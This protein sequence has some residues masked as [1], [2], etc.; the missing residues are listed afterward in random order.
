MGRCVVVS[1]GEIS[2]YEMMSSLVRE[3]DFVIYCDCALRHRDKLSVRADLTVGDFDSFERP[4]EDENVI[5]LPCEKDDTDTLFALRH[6]LSL[7]YRD[8]LILGALGGRTDHAL[9]NIFLL[10]FLRDHDAMGMI[11]TELEDIVL[12]DSEK[13]PVCE[14]DES[15]S[16]FSLLALEGKAEG[17]T[18]TGAKYEISDRCI[19]S[20][21][22]YAVSNEVSKGGKA[23]VSVTNGSLLLVKVH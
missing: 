15:C 18:I 11:A 1:G 5:V 23:R 3:D 14:I 9:S 2:D 6:A 8:F 7:G 20:G 22:Q 10:F 19:S 13:N 21:F 4:E 12:I 16:Y 17:V